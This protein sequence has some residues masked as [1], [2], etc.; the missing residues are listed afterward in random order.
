LKRGGDDI[1]S[2]YYFL[3]TRVLRKEIKLKVKRYGK[4]KTKGIRFY[5]RETV[6]MK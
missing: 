4:R 2:L 5:T 3:V 1:A 6:C